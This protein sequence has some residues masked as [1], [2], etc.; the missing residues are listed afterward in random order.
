MTH[1]RTLLKVDRNQFYP[2]LWEHTDKPMVTIYRLGHT[3]KGTLTYW[4]KC[5]SNREVNE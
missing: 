2:I 3:S 1:T 4:Q 5:R